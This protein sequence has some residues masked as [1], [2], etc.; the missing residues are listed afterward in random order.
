MQQFARCR[1]D[2]LLA[3][4]ANAWC[5]AVISPLQRILAFTPHD[6]PFCPKARNCFSNKL[7]ASNSGDFQPTQILIVSV[8]CSGVL[9]ALVLGVLSTRLI[10]LEISVLG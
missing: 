10:S 9:G 8:L 5:F 4:L 1:E 6:R 7:K 2:E 3:V